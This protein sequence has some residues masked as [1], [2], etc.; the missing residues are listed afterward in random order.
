MGSFAQ[1]EIDGFEIYSTKNSVDNEVMTIF[2]ESEQV[3]IPNCPPSE[4]VFGETVDSQDG[5]TD[6]R[7]VYTCEV[8]K[9]RDRLDIM[10]FT[11]TRVNREFQELLSKHVESIDWWNGDPDL[12]PRGA[13]E[14]QF[15]ESLTFESYLLGLRELFRLEIQPWDT[16]N[17]KRPQLSEEAK[18]ILNDH[19]EHEIGFFGSDIR[20][21]I[22]TACELAPDAG[23]I[24][25][26]VT[27]LV[28][29]G[30]FEADFKFVE[31]ST[32]ALVARH[33]ENAKRIILTE[34]KTDRR[35]LHGAM[36]L[37]HPHLLDYYSFFDF[38]EARFGG[39]VGPLV[40]LVKGFIAAGVSNRV[41]AL[42]DNDTAA[43][44]AMRLL[45]GIRIPQNIA[46][47]TYPELELL[48]DYPT[49]GPTGQTRL[50]VN[51]MAASIELFLGRDV[52]T[53]EESGQLSPVQWKGYNEALRQYQGEV[54]NKG[55]LQEKF[56]KKFK[57]ALADP[58]L[59]E[60]QDWSGLS[61]ILK[62]IFN[63]FD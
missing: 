4:S 13:A 52:L 2:R 29:G 57:A 11:L 56:D 30:Y 38:D 55:V 15:L 51:G 53:D 9:V 35:I 6:C 60:I 8:W 54:L 42:F 39:G 14:I 37:L 47:L 50:N 63:V 20:S 22:R 16:N 24:T 19:E 41:I 23:W 12:D 36:S 17:S 58:K 43:K 1:L 10:G 25:L 26:D 27:D 34:G 3:V 7:V 49:I 59:V 44:E 28:A 62:A 21:L 48:Q 46:V 32:H 18:Y 61:A 40:A 31:K 45:D 33:P 5:E